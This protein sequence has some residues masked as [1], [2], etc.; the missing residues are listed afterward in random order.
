MLGNRDRRKTFFAI[1]GTMVMVLSALTAISLAVPAS[2][3]PSLAAPPSPNASIASGPLSQIAAASTYNPTGSTALPANIASSYSIAPDNAAFN[4]AQQ[5]VLQ[6]SLSPT[7]SLSNLAANVNNPSS[8]SYHQYLSLSGIGSEVGVAPATYGAIASYFGSHGITV[9]THADM[10][11]LTLMGTPAQL[12]S[13]FNTHIQAFAESYS[14]ASLYNPVFDK[15]VGTQTVTINGVAYNEPEWQSQPL[16]FYANTAGLSLPAGIAKYVSGVTGFGDDFAQPQVQAVYGAFPGQLSATTVNNSSSGYS[17]LGGGPLPLG[18]SSDSSIVKDPAQLGISTGDVSKSCQANYVWAY[19]GTEATQLFFPSSMPTLLGACTLFTGA[20]TLQSEPDYGQGVT[21]A[22]IE[23]GAVDPAQ[24]NAF[25]QLTFGKSGIGPNGLTTNLLSRTTFIDLGA[26]SLTQAEDQGLDYGWY[27]ETAL[28]IEYAATMAPEAHIDLVSVPDPQFSAFDEAYSFVMANLVGNPICDIPATDPVLGPVFVYGATTDPNGGSACQVAIASNSYGS[29]ETVTIYEGSPMYITVESQ[30]LSEMSVMGVTSFFASGDGGGVDAVVSDFMPADSP[31]V[32]SVGGGAVTASDQGVTFPNT[33]KYAFLQDEYYFGYSYGAI[34]EVAPE[35][36]LQSFTYWATDSFEGIFG[37]SG[38]GGFGESIVTP[39]AWYAAGNDTYNTGARMDP[40]I[41]G[42]AAFNMS[43]YYGICYDIYFDIVSCSSPSV[44][45]EEGPWN[46]IYGGTSF[47]TPINAGGWALVEEQLNQRYGPSAGMTG[48]IGALLYESRNAPLAGAPGSQNPFVPMTNIGIDQNYEG[49]GDY[50]PFSSYVWYYENLS[51]QVPDAVDHPW[52]FASLFNPA[53]PPGWTDGKFAGGSSLWNNLQGLGMPNYDLLDQAIVGQTA[54]SHAIDNSQ[55][56]VEL[57]GTPDQDISTLYCGQTYTFQIVTTLAGNA[58]YKVVA[59]SGTPNDGAWGGGTT[60]VIWV[61]PSTDP[62]LTFT[63]TPTCPSSS[64][65]GPNSLNNTAWH[66]AYFLVSVETSNPLGV[67]WTFQQFADQV[68]PAG[69]LNLCIS[70][71]YDICQTAVA[72]ETMFHT[73]DLEGFYNLQGQANAFVTLTEPDGQVTPVESATVVQTSVVTTLCPA[74]SSTEAYSCDPTLNPATYAPGVAIG[75]YLTDSRGV[76]DI[77]DNAFIAESS[78]ATPATGLDN[79]Y[80]DSTGGSQPIIPP[81]CLQT[82]VYTITAYFGGL[83]SNSVTV[84]VEPQMGSFFPQLSLNA[85]GDVVGFVQFNQM[86]NVQY[87]NISIGSGPGEYDNVSFLPA[88]AP[89]GIVSLFGSD[90][91][92]EFPENPGAYCTTSGA[93]VPPTGPTPQEVCQ[94]GDASAFYDS[95]DWLCG[96]GVKEGVIEVD[97]T[98]PA[99]AGSGEDGAIVVSELAV[100]WNDLNLNEG[101]FYGECFSFPDTQYGIYW[102]DPL[103]FLPTHLSASQTSSTVNGIDTFTFSGTSF[104]GASGALELVS[105][106]GTTVLATGLSG[107][108]SLETAGLSDGSYKVVYVETAPGAVTSQQSV[109]FY[110]DNTALALSSDVA[111]LTAQVASD[112]S[113]ISTLS[114]NLAADTAAISALNA[115]VASMQAGWSATNASLASE[116]AAL[117]S[118]QSALA[119]AN[120][121]VAT[122]TAQV[123]TLQGQLATETAT[124][125]SL[126]AQLSS[127]QSQNGADQST[128]A[129]LQ[130][131]LAA[132]NA[133]I[134]SDQTSLANAQGQLSA[135]QAQIATLTAQVAT[136]QK[137]LNDKKNYVAPAWYDTSLGSGLILLIAG[138]GALIGALAVY[139]VMRGR[140]TEHDMP[141]DPTGANP[142]AAPT[143]PNATARVSPAAQPAPVAA[144]RSPEDVLRRA[145]A[146]RL[147]LIRKG[148][149]EGAAWM[150]NNIRVLRDMTGGPTGT[151]AQL[152][153]EGSDLMYR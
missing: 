23:V 82:Q 25:S 124:V 139:G 97:L 1:L 110:T 50:A 69:T 106:A 7:A 44:V 123:S 100:G 49:I 59:Y 10:L 29:G 12:S 9:E 108:Y 14:N 94:A 129:S 148:D 8:G 143:S 126:N 39:Q 66:Y 130:S 140:R 83:V 51:A 91:L 38:G 141:S 93:G 135:D 11:T 147:V 61:F 16:V 64:V 40:E 22:V 112:A 118:A 137:E 136:L 46:F 32:V 90:G 149:L 88:C 21:I 65:T 81:E 116:A 26:S 13:A 120:A 2:A 98:P 67:P 138:V 15:I 104:P 109:G 47:A 92:T 36:N 71:L 128:I 150:A 27:I 76:A 117:S 133:V 103:V 122:L 24:L 53:V 20:D 85:A 146:A 60:T 18:Y 79:E 119:S 41:S 80:G 113:T 127:L 105:A 70:D 6:V 78:C 111:T 48:D 86:T 84:Y 95:A 42:P 17:T 55:F 75:N 96:S 62:S 153:P 132:A 37:G 134:A 58:P 77:W 31:T 144:A 33:G 114:A 99:G 54:T 43:I 73:Y 152:A 19:A 101:C 3:S 57:Y 107:T 4:A 35:T 142:P 56:Y 34:V 115:Q 121:Q 151:P 68:M 5:I 74:L 145:Q 87:V 131:Q 125:A 30:L 28:D 63:Y 102:Q 52:W 72:E 45:Y 89:P